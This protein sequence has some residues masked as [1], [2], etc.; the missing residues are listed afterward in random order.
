VEEIRRERRLL[1]K[2][3]D[4]VTLGSVGSTHKQDPRLQGTNEKAI[5]ICICI[6]YMF[7]RSI[8]DLD[9]ELVKINKK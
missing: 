1:Q 8:H 4:W 9:I 2:S 6:Y 3:G 7:I 5:C